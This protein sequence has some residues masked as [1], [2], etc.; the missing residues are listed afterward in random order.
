MNTQAKISGY[1]QQAID[2]LDSTGTE[3]KIEY[4]YTGKYFPDDTEKRDIYQFTLTNAR[5]SY[6]DKFGDSIQNTE[7]RAF[8]MQGRCNYKEDYSRAKR[9][10]IRVSG[11]GTFVPYRGKRL[12]KPSAY[13]IL[14]CLDTYVP[15]TF[16]E[17]CEEYGYNEKP[18]S[19]HDTVMRT[20]LAVREQLEGLRRIFTADQLEQLAEIQ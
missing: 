8:M 5:G 3:F 6:S 14:A 7:D 13:S 4:L 2:F 11:A 10:G 12:P 15:D 17:F 9:V 1:D 20:F 18:L 16:K 19:E